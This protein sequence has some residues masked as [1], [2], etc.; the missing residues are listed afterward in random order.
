MAAD[1][2]AK[3]DKNSVPAIIGVNS[4][5]E[6]R[7]IQ[8][9]DS[10]DLLVAATGTWTVTAVASG[11]QTVTATD[12]D[13]RNLTAASDTVTVT[14]A[15]TATVSA[16]NLDI[17][18]LTSASDS[19]T[20]VTPADVDIRN[21]T[22][23]SDTVTVTGAVTTSGTAT[24]TATDLDIRNLTAASDTVTVTGA[25]TTSGTVTATGTVFIN[26]GGNTITVDGAVT[27]S[28]TTTA[29]GTVSI[30][31]GIYGPVD[32]TV[33]SYIGLDVTLT[34][35]GNIADVKSNGALQVATELLTHWEYDNEDINSGATATVT[36]S[37][38]GTASATILMTCNNCAGTVF[39]RADGVDAADDVGI[40][41]FAN[42]CV[43]IEQGMLTD[44][45]FYNSHTGVCKV[46]LQ[47]R[48]RN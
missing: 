7:R 4:S 26:D 29:T 19:V 5:D 24:V 17:R 38:A 3:R 12:L 22:A 15:V 43:V 13:I 32:V 28:G 40:P 6:I 44:A 2:I 10:G 23:A 39:V 14:G 33:G 9:T 25:V 48:G 46:A 16:T 8:T 35:G 27:T 11:T 47:W 37:Y 36:Y 45:R 1:E 30:G 34:D 31:D 18:D 20:V 42:S 21:L 41:L